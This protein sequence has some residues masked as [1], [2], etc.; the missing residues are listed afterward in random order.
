MTL[1]FFRDWSVL[2]FG[3]V[4]ALSFFVPGLKYYRQRMANVAT[5]ARVD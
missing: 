3:I 5:R 4:T 1:P 2:L